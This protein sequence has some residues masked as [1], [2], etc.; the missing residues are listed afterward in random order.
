MPYKNPLKAFLTVAPF[1]YTCFSGFYL[2]LSLIFAIKA[3][4]KIEP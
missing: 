1:A 2:I 3:I 4:K